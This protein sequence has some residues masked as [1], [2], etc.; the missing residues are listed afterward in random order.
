MVSIRNVGFPVLGLVIL[1]SLLACGSSGSAPTKAPENVSTVLFEK[2]VDLPSKSV[3]VVVFHITLPIGFKTPAHTHKGPGPRYAIEGTTEIV[4]G[5][6][7][8]TYT[9][10]EVFWESGAL[11]TGE[12]VGRVPVELIAVRLLPMEPEPVPAEASTK[13]SRL[14]FEKVVDLPSKRVNVVVRHVTLPGGFK[15]PAQTHEGPGP[16]YVLEGTTEIVADKTTRTYAAGE[17]F[18]ESGALMTSENL[19]DVR[20]ELVSF[21]LLPVE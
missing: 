4:A 16:R 9:A 1:V 6:T 3:N 13:M 20:T 2:V 17:V 10:G 14:L 8:E 15:T 5:K 11:M 19:G 12:N 7:T 21:Q 18:W